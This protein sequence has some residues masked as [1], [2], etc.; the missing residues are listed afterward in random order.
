[1][2]HKITHFMIQRGIPVP[3]PQPGQLI[4]NLWTLVFSTLFLDN[5]NVQLG[6]EPER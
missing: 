1:M 3:E 2:I 5:S 4:Q 6:K